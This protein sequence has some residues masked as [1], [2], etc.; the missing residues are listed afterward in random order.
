M[1]PVYLGRGGLG[2]G[3][4][5]RGGGGGGGGGGGEFFFRFWGGARGRPGRAIITLLLCKNL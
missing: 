4:K 2:G 1:N 5:G 3:G